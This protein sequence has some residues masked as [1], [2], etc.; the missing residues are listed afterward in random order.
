MNR[1]GNADTQSIG[2]AD[3]SLTVTFSGGIIH[4]PPLTVGGFRTQKSHPRVASEVM[5]EESC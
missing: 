3:V 4:A 1:I 2:N 5:D